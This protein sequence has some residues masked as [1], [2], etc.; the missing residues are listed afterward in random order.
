MDP[1]KTR[2]VSQRKAWEAP[3]R[4]QVALDTLLPPCRLPPLG[5][6]EAKGPGRL[7]RTA[8]RPRRQGR[9]PGPL[10]S[11]AYLGPHAALGDARRQSSR[12]PRFLHGGPSGR[13]PARAAV[14]SFVRGKQFTLE[15]NQLSRPAFSTSTSACRPISGSGGTGV[16][17]KPREA[18]NSREE[19]T[20]RLFTS[21][22]RAA[23]LQ[24]GPEVPDAVW[25]RAA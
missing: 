11:T 18:S 19:I 25:V 13:S 10:S 2:A 9:S 17:P 21:G 5:S 4:V 1:E 8:S 14:S 7:F 3:T 6:A 23:R 16:D 15:A 22:L 12:S 24:A 20:A